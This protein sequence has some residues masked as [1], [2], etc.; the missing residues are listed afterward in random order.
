MFKEVESLKKAVQNSQG[1]KL[2]TKE[3]DEW[4]HIFHVFVYVYT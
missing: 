4:S 2:F 1:K 3:R